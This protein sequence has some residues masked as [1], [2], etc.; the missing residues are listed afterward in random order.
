MLHLAKSESKLKTGFLAARLFGYAEIL[1]LFG[2]QFFWIIYSGDLLYHESLWDLVA[3]LGPIAVVIIVGIICQMKNLRAAIRKIEWLIH[4]LICAIILTIILLIQLRDEFSPFFPFTWLFHL[5]IVFF[6]LVLTVNVVSNMDKPSLL[7]YLKEKSQLLLFVGVLTVVWILT[8][9]IISILHYAVHYWIAAALFHA[10]MIP[11]SISRQHTNTEVLSNGP[12]SPYSYTV[13]RNSR[14]LFSK[15]SMKIDLKKFYDVLKGVFLG[16]L[17]VIAWY[18]WGHFHGIF[19]SIEANYHLV[20]GFFISPLFYVG[21]GLGIGLQVLEVN[22]VGRITLVGDAIGFLTVG[23][24]LIGIYGLA[25][26]AL[27]YALVMLLLHESGQNP[28]TYAGAIIFMQFLWYVGLA[29]FVS[30]PSL[31]TLEPGIKVLINI[32]LFGSMGGV[33]GISFGCIAIEKLLGLR[34]GKDKQVMEGSTDG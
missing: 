31:L 20:V 29:L 3:F 9:G 7:T 23:L 34:K 5:W 25:P 28:V 21:M 27:G 26:F 16:L 2:L 22:K 24:S 15:K 8:L 6:G 10:I 4:L 33:L 32:I 17:F 11:I 14:E 12:P 30:Y 1:I 13:Y 18:V 19:G